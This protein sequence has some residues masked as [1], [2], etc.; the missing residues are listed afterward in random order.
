MEPSWSLAVG[1]FGML[2][3]LLGWAYQLGFMASRVTRGES[4]IRNLQERMTNHHERTDLHPS[5]EWRKEIRERFDR[6]D[7]KLDNLPC[8]TCPISKE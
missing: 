4:D 5:D 6:F 7:T 1:L 2:I 8:K 3:A